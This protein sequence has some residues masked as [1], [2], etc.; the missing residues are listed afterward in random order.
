M[1]HHILLDIMADEIR[2]RVFGL[3]GGLI[4]E[5][6]IPRQLARKLKSSEIPNN[7]V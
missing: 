2:L 3:Q 4:D 5:V 7:N 6:N 1:H